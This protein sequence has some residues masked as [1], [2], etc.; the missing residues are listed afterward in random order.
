VD[1]TDHL[2][3]AYI[4]GSR[5]GVPRPFGDAVLDGVN[6]YVTA[7]AR[8][9]AE[10][11]DK[12]AKRLHGHNNGVARTRTQTSRRRWRRGCSAACTSG[13]TRRPAVDGWIN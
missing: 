3:N 1:L 7:A 8:A 10:H 9:A 11:Y 2:W 12:L 13:C 5:A 4:G 6:F